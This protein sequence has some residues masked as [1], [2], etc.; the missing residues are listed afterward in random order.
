MNASTPDDDEPTSFVGKTKALVKK[1]KGKIVAAGTVAVAVVGV[2]ARLHD[3]ME[4]AEERDAVGVEDFS[5]VPLVE[6]PKRSA[7]GLHPVKG[8]LVDLGGRQASARAQ[9]NYRHD[10]GSD[11]PPGKTYRPP[12]SRGSVKV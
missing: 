6:V 2:L 9:E 5:E 8:S 7:S 1:H 10:F 3:E 12:H 11:L 4:A